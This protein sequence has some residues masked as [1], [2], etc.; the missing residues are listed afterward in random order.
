MNKIAV[1]LPQQPSYLLVSSCRR[2]NEN[3]LAWIS[4]EL[5]I[6]NIEKAAECRQFV[7]AMTN[8]FEVVVVTLGD[9]SVTFNNSNAPLVL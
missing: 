3:F 9:L 8:G 6:N 5:V 2:N 4:E 7:Q 1:S